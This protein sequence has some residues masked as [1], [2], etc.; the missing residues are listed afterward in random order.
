MDE[1]SDESVSEE[2]INEQPVAEKSINEPIADEP[3]VNN[4]HSWVCE[5]NKT[6]LDIKFSNK[7]ELNNHYEM[8]IEA[9]PVGNDFKIRYI[10]CFMHSIWDDILPDIAEERTRSLFIKSSK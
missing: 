7:R 10:R 5:K 6:T 8:D 9:T 2:S 1:S 4:L 3:A